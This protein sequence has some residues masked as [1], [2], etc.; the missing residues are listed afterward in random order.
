MTNP[1]SETPEAALRKI[2]IFSDLSNDQ[3][4][5]FVS[6]ANEIKLSAGDVIIHEGDPADALFVVLEG[7]VRGRRENGGGAAPGFVARAGEVTGMLPFSRLTH[8]GMTARATT[9]T[10]GLRLHKDHFEEMLRRIPQLLPRLI[11][12]LADRIREYSRA[13]QQRDKLSA[14]GKLSAGLAHELNNPA[15]AAVR[16]A[17]G[18]RESMQELR[19][20]NKTL[21]DESLSCLE[22]SE[23]ASFEEDLMDQLASKPPLDALEQSDIEEELAVWLNRRNI[24]NASRLASGLVEAGV[25]SAAACRQ[26]EESLDDDLNT[27]EAL[28]A[29]FEFVRDANTAM[30]AVEFREGNTAPA[31]DVLARFDRIFAV[32]EPT[33]A[34]G[35]LSDARVE[36]LI[37]ERAAAKKARN[38]GRSDQIRQELLDAGIVLEDTKEGARWKRK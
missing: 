21:D 18:L 34:I 24:P 22:R 11:G 8:F 31:L 2:D 17:Q 25:D 37:A 33:Q 23:L 26:F 9:P 20:I 3:L 5:W 19:K 27:A 35:G 6:S 7:E 4:H 36:E 29:L 10:W 32:L 30:D 38:F 16:A 13:E 28:A 12:V 14:L 1:P 15:A